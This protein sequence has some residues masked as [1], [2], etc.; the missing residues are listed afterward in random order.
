MHHN[1]N[2]HAAGHLELNE[3]LLPNMVEKTKSV[4]RIKELT[5]LS[6]A[7]AFCFCPIMSMFSVLNS[8]AVKNTALMFASD[9]VKAHICHKCMYTIDD[10]CQIHVALLQ[11]PR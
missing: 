6:I 10:L 8:N 5:Y 9:P 7:F 4:E 3:N 11:M 2:I 1:G